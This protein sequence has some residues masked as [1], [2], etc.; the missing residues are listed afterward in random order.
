MGQLSK[1]QRVFCVKKYYET[2]KFSVV[3]NLFRLS[4]P[5]RNPPEKSTIWRLVKKYEDHATSLNRNAKNSGRRRTGRSNNNIDLVQRTLENNPDGVS[6]RENGVGLSSATF[7]R[8][9]RLD[10]KWHPYRMKRRHQLKPGD[11]AR[12][13]NFARWLINKV[14]NPNF[15]AQLFIGDEAGFAMNGKVSSQ[16]V[17]KYA[18]KGDVP[19]FTYDVN[20]SRAKLMVW[21]GLI[22]NGTLIG[23]FFFEG[24]V[25]GAKYLQLLNE[26]VLPELFNLFPNQFDNGHFTRLWWAQDGA[27]AHRTVEIS[28][29]LTEFFQNRIIALD[30]PTEWPPRSPDLTPCDYFLWGY[31]KSKVFRSPPV[32]I[33]DLQARITH[34]ANLLKQDR[35]LV[36]RAVRDMIKRANV[37]IDRNGGHVEGKY[38]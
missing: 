38:R 13:L 9:C 33:A 34:E 17:R 16:N 1:E 31:L 4:F 24:N 23:P 20:E 18:P 30:H 29:F 8:I 6:C 3:R 5:N 28:E 2:K 35:N 36:R 14:R 25:T 32:D 12:R 22:G 26:K 19:E 10:L 27:P 21:I 11:Y 15:L 37:C 7:N